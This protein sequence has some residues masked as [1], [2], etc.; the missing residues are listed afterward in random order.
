MPGV[1]FN[2]RATSYEG[3][4][5]YEFV[6][7]HPYGIDYT[8]RF[9]F[10][11]NTSLVMIAH[12]IDGSLNT[13]N[14]IRNDNLPHNVT[15]CTIYGYNGAHIIVAGE[16]KVS[17][18]KGFNPSVVSTSSIDG[19]TSISK[20]LVIPSYD[21]TPAI[22]F[23]ASTDSSNTATV[24]INGKEIYKS[25]TDTS[26]KLS[27]I[28]F[29]IQKSQT[30]THEAP[31]TS[32]IS[33]Y[34]IG[35]P[36]FISGNVK[37][38]D[39]GTNTWTSSTSSVNCISEVKPSGNDSEFIGILVGYTAKDGRI[40]YNDNEAHETIP[41]SIVF[42]SHGDYYLHVEDASKYHVGDLVTYDGTII[43]PDT[44]LTNKLTKI[45]IGTV[46]GIIDAN[47]LAVFR[48]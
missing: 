37:S 19:I 22:P 26:T 1:D 36:V 29:T 9:T 23:I 6:G 42:A 31:F 47:T 11:S 30:V 32:N 21:T 45:I 16:G 24:T 3:V 40:I 17:V 33:E 2:T 25:L 28:E 44:P 20:V 48:S 43:S 15:C 12:F 18:F 27:S 4:T 35:R 38:F 14:V 46:T 7:D 8:S 13:S 5:E 34:H 41:R 39:F 10:V